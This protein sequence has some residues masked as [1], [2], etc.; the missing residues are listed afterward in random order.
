M[1]TRR[2]FLKSSAMAG[3]GAAVFWHGNVLFARTA[4]GVTPLFTANP[5]LD[6]SNVPKYVTDL[7]IPP[8]MPRIG[9]FR[10][11]GGQKVDYYEIA[12]KQFV[13]QILPPGLGATTVWS[14]GSAW[15]P[16]TFNYPAF[17]IEAQSGIPVR[18][19]WINSLV[20]SRGNYL[21]HL[22]PVDQTLHWAN[23]GGGAAGRDMVGATTQAPYT[24]PV[25]L[26]T[27]VHGAHTSDESDG[28]TE[29]WY[30]P[31][32]R[33]IPASFARTGSKYDYFR[34]KFLLKRGL[35]WLPGSA[36]YQ[37]P[38]DQP[39][40]TLWYHDHTMGMTRLNVYAGPAGFYHVRGGAYDLQDGSLPG[41]A[42]AL[43]DA[44][45]TRYYE[46]PLA[47]QD[48][49]FNADGSLFYPSSRLFFD[50]FTGPYIGD[51]TAS[52]DV[53]PI[54]NPEFFANTMVVNGRTWP[55][56]VVEPRR[57]RF[58]LLN[59]CNAR[60]LI[61][62]LTT[63][64]VPASAS[65]GVWPP[66]SELPFWR[67]GAEGGFLPSAIAQGDVLI[68]PAERADVVVDFSGLAGQ[69]VYLINLGP[70]EPY[71]GGDFGSDEQ[72]EGSAADFVYA[73]PGTTGQ[74]M[75]FDV[76]APLSRADTSKNPAI[77]LALPT[78]P[79]L[80]PEV[81]T[82]RVSL[83]EEMSMIWDGPV[84]A[85]LGSFNPSTGANM[86]M[87]WMDPVTET[88][89]L[90]DV[91]VWEIHNFTVDA[92]PMHIHEVQFEVVD[93]E[94]L[95]SDS[96][97]AVVDNGDLQ[98]ASQ[99]FGPEPWEVG[100]K[101]TVIAYPGEITRVKVKFDNPGLFVWHCH[102]VEH[103][104]NEMMRPLF[105]RRPGQVV[106]ADADAVDITGEETSQDE[107]FEPEMSNQ[108]FMPV[109]RR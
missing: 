22:L 93:R 36:T 26:V 3:V 60:F 105:V 98:N 10:L 39:A 79:K 53:P 21:P 62:R 20:D 92:H 11:I 90:G 102:I 107:A 28:Y 65:S 17:T 70:D 55:K 24:G 69:R 49:S 18:V 94:V 12:V 75:M 4:Q 38:N 29:A 13:Q 23:P 61:L 84:A 101:D 73:N 42:P 15:H 56:L 83:N 63:A 51:T 66:P 47:I 103:E 96:P 57:Y 88:P 80:G 31:L 52:S 5:T 78:V 72:V 74:V 108:M 33:N 45:G 97:K 106:A 32:A 48:R 30:L 77:G 99:V 14:Y 76:S 1:L 6:L 68:S 41:P 25:P 58:R 81:V 109:I 82:R 2:D 89:T 43:G 71:G 46:I 67:I 44:A 85:I 86:P 50:S 37:Y 104:D 100:L 34:L 8:A 7:I 16:N 64:D 35:P 19:R 54:W 87:R 91:E 59:G 40:S 95:T 27:H 9:R